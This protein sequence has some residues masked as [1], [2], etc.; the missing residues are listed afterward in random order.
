MF[1]SYGTTTRTAPLAACGCLISHKTSK[2]AP[3]PAGPIRYVLYLH[4]EC[5]TTISK[6]QT[7]K[8]HTKKSKGHQ[9]T[10]KPS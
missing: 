6:T 5:S 2:T 7:L 9:R 1:D 4:S 8:N 3:P 10:S